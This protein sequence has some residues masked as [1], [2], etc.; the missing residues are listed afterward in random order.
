MNLLPTALKHK[1]FSWVASSPTLLNIYYGQRQKFKGLL[2]N[3]ST[4]I[5]IEGFPRS[6]NTFAVIAFKQAQVKEYQVAHHLHAEAQLKLAV[7]YNTPAIV[8]LRE[9]ISAISSLLV[10]DSN[11]NA[12]QAL[13]RYI[14]FYTVV[15][16]LK[17]QLVIAEFNEVTQNM[18]AIIKRCN[19]QF[20]RNFLSFD[21][22][23]ANTQNVFDEIKA[24]NQR[25]EQG[26]PSMIAMP[27][28]EKEHRQIEYLSE[29]NN[30]PLF[31]TANNLYISLKS[32][33]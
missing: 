12:T 24:I 22:T 20:S 27:N 29:I 19:T 13:Q 8:V 9:P 28:K 23:S 17:A 21:H 33:P 2:V 30:H 5:V 16:A 15:K 32:T 31:T 14:D 1:L 7:K 3:S 11:Y 10:R 18:G 26:K 4:D 25:K 6:A